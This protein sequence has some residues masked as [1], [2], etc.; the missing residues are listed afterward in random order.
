MA[1]GGS[2]ARRYAEAL[3]EVAARENA[4]P[5]YRASVERVREALGPDVVRWLRD[6]VVPV[7]RRRAA[8]EAATKGEPVALRAVLDLLLERDRLVLLPGIAAAFGELADRRDGVVRAKITTP[9]ALDESH[10]ADVV[11]RL[12][13]TTGKRIR[14]TFAVDP[15]LLGGVTV[16]LGDRLID[17]SIRAQLDELRSQLASS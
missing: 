10:R 8:L 7:E 2:A 3:Y 9:V 16:Q 4:V 11:R 13:Q 5:A 6:R 14:P 12:E 1:V 15:A 17:A